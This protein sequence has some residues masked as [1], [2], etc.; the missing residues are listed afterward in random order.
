MQ[1]L[2]IPQKPSLRI[3]GI[4]REEASERQKIFSME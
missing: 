4:Q 1:E 2:G 3:T